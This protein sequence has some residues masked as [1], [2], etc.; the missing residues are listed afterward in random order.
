[1]RAPF[2]L[3]A[4]LLTFAASCSGDPIAPNRGALDSAR[5]IWELHG[6]S[7]Y[8]FTIKMDCFC[9][10]NGAI[11]ATVVNDS[12]ISATVIATGQS[13]EPGSVPGIK[14]LFDF[15]DQGLA[16]NAAV[17]DVAYDPT[18]GFPAKIVYVGSYSIADDG[19]T[20]TV[21]DVV[22]SGT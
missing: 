1:M 7:S 17:L 11:R 22:L 21:S 15:I 18:L 5:Q 9:A 20:Y 14:K 6:N 12:T 13:I 16:Q 2:K 10:V 19:I 3:F 8:Q 4:V